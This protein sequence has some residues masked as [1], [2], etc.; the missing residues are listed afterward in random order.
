MKRFGWSLVLFLLATGCVR[1]HHVKKVEPS[2]PYVK[3][4]LS[5]GAQFGAL[6]PPVQNTVRAE[7]GTAEVADITKDTSSGK[8][9]YKIFFKSHEIYPPLYIAADGS[10]LNPDLSLAVVAPDTNRTGLKL[11][12]LPPDALRV[13]HDRAPS[14]EI[15]SIKRETW[16]DRVVY[17]VSFKDETTHP[18]LYV[19]SDGTVFSESPK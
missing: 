7:V 8:A 19:A 10:V 4:L 2:T 17:I 6:P 13:V 5:P 14:F 12:E 11:S 18:K 3:P 16:G 1:T 9:V 15:A